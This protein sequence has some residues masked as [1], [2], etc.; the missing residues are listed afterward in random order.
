MIFADHNIEID[1][2]TG[3]LMLFQVWKT[4]NLWTSE[5]GPSFIVFEFDWRKLFLEKEAI[6]FFVLKRENIW[7]RIKN[8]KWYCDSSVN[9]FATRFSHPRLNAARGFSSNDLSSYS[10][11]EL[12][13]FELEAKQN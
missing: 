13:F 7:R 9:K 4:N 11:L 5:I 2:A 8:N 6:L 10:L 1:I 3:R 12:T